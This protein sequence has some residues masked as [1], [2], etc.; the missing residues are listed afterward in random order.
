MFSFLEIAALL[1]GLSALFG[2]LN[3]KFLPFPHAVGLLVMSVASSGVLIAV[4]RAVPDQ[5]IFKSLTSP[6]DGID[7]SHL[8]MDGMLAFLVFAG[9]LHVDFGRLRA[10]AW[11]VAFLA[12]VGTVLS[13]VIIGVSVWWLASY[14]GWPLTLGWA[15]AFGALISPTDPV[16]VL[17]I[18]RTVAL[19][20]S[21]EVELQGEALFNDGVGIVLVAAL[22]AYA[23]GQETHG[24]LATIG[25]FL[26]KEAGGGLLLGL[27]TG[28]VAYWGMRLIDDYPVE[29]LI[30]LALVTGTYAIAERLGISGPLSMASAGLLIGTRGPQDAMSGRTQTYLFGLWTLIDEILNSVLFL[31]IGLEVLVISTGDVSFGFAAAAIPIVIL[32]RLIAVFCPLVIA[33]FGVAMSLRNVPFL[34]WAGVRGGISVALALS[35]PPSD[36]KPLILSA[37]YAVVVF[38]V[39]VQG[40]TLPF[41]ARVTDVGGKGPP[42]PR[43]G[44]G[45]DNEEP[46]AAP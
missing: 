18:L 30:S 3:H 4:D 34:T 9:A 33:P 19:P 37:T 22:T 38:S 42:S 2:W 36:A 21:L 7:F 44:T 17:S 45:S 23:A 8:V 41:V 31:L 24:G 46:A 1:L 25:L 27:V 13:T 16:A 43:R 39:V 26:V 28:M 40:L 32:A 35:L 6:L 20:P 5:H 15:L 14:F 29:V 10:R 12:I 11:Q